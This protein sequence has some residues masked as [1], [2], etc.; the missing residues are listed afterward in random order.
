MEAQVAPP[1]ARRIEVAPAV[2]LAARS[3]DGDGGRPFVLVHGLASNAHLWDGVAD[4]LAV[5]GHAVT[6]VDQRGHGQSDKPDSGYD[7]ATVTDDLAALIGAL[8]YERP[9]LAGQS[10]GGNVVLELAWRLPDRGSGV[11]GVGRG[12]LGGGA[13]VP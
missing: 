8:G 1:T 7:F 12:A 11:V 5:L 3:W 13:R 2:S 6:T 10:W 9:V 4:R